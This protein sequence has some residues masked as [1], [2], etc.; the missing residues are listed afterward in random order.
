[1]SS[2][3]VGLLGALAIVATSLASGPVSAVVF[4]PATNPI[5]GPPQ[6]TPYF[7]TVT[8]NTY[9]ESR[10]SDDFNGDIGNNSPANVATVLSGAEW[11]NTPLT[12]VGGGNCGTNGV[13]CTS[14]PNVG[15][16]GGSS[17]SI[18]TSGA[19][20]FA[21]HFD[22][23]YIAFLYDPF[24][25]NFEISGLSQGV[26]TIL[27]FNCPDCGGP[28]PNPGPGETPI[29]GAAFLMGSVLAGGAG[30]GAWKRRR[31]IQIA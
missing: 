21:V 2:L 1:M 22:A 14:D 7:W 26:S 6:D 11:F 19:N 5:P 24:I 12:F 27:A 30:F 3:R 17:G 10:Y 29:P 9:T 25:F 18:I 23:Q 4:D 8:P 20:V 31:K 16:V 28:G 13:T 15:G